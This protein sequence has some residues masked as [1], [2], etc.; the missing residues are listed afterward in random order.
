M[1]A[2]VAV[3]LGI[4]DGLDIDVAAG[5]YDLAGG[6]TSADASTLA[7]DEMDVS[8]GVDATFATDALGGTL[9]TAVGFDTDTINGG[10]ATNGADLKVTLA[11]QIP[12]TEFV[13]AWSDADLS[14]V[15]GVVSFTT[16]VTY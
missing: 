7:D 16:K 12:N 9:T 10:D 3:G 8:I 15:G 13:L 11:G 5:L 6:D 2:E 1:D 14:E 4:I